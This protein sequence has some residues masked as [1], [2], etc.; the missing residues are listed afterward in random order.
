MFLFSERA[1]LPVALKKITARSWTQSC[2]RELQYASNLPHNAFF[3]NAKLKRQSG[4]NPTTLSCNASAAK[5]CS[6]NQPI[7]RRVFIKKNIF[8]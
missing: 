3:K 2:D 5:I 6:R 8:L 4:P 1:R 7:A